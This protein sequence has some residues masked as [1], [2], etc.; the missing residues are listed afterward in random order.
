MMTT[1]R[2]SIGVPVY[3]GGSLLSEMLESLVT[4]TF[5]DFEIVI[6]DNASTDDTSETARRFA[7]RDRRVRYYRNDTNIGAAPNFNRVFELANNPVYF[8]WA[9]HDDLYKPTYLERC[10]EVLDEEPDVVVSYTIVDVIDDTGENLL[11][12]HPFYWYGCLES[13]IDDHGR[14]GWMMGPLHLAETAD[15]ARRYSEFL[16]RMIA[17]LPIFGIIRADALRRSS[18][19]RSYYGSDRSLLAQLVLQGRF[20][21]VHEHL[22]INRYHKSASRLLSEE[23]QQAWIDT[24]RRSSRS[25]RL[26][27]QIDLVCA[28]LTA[29]LKIMD[30]ARCFGVAGLHITRRNAG[31]VLRTVLAG[32][33]MN[34]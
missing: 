23:E 29:R 22:Y 27:Q 4:Q 32:V 21:Q 5:T 12:K 33:A 30:A 7:E 16:N 18:L 31:R 24:T 28:P 10:V 2:V 6:S 25:P 9:A 3:N 1:S 15:R 13:Y 8:K 34:Q 17:C 11:G 20:R 14:T 26:Q 19:H